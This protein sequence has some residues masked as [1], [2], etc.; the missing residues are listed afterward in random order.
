MRYFPDGHGWLAFQN[1]LREQVQM[2]DILR[3]LGGIGSRPRCRKLPD[4]IEQV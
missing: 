4:R 2:R 3:P 1:A